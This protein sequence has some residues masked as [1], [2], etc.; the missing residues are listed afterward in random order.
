MPAER[1]WRDIVKAVK[2]RNWLW[3]NGKRRRRSKLHLT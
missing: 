3:N 1:I 2:A